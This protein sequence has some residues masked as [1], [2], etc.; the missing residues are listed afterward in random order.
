MPT[1][2]LTHGAGSNRNAPLLVALETEFLKLGF[3]VERVDLKFRLSGRSGPPRPADQAQDR[4]G[5]AEHLKRLRASDSK[6]YLGGHS[7]GGRQGSMLLAERPELAD[8]LL[9]LAYP[10][11]PPG[12]PE[13]LR[14]AHLPSLQTPVLLVSGGKDE[15]GTESELAEAA[16][17]IPGRKQLKIFPALKHDLGGGRKGV[18]AEIAEAFHRFI[19]ET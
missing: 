1:I 14:T 18:A 10:L 15:F 11:H 19:L 13:Q 8:G 12:K 5:L 2:L 6:V 4:E 9:L 7:Y 3:A 17:I 16:R